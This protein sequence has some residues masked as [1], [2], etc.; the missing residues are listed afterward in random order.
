MTG[1]KRIRASPLVLLAVFA[2]AACAKQES[3]R[4][5]SAS[6]VL[7]APQGEFLAYEHD[8]EVALAG[9]RIPAALKA[10]QASCQRKAFGDCVVLHVSQQGGDHPRG[11]LTVRIV[12]AGV[13]PMIASASAGGEVGDRS[14]HA[15][16]LAEAVRDN[17]LARTRLQKEQ[18]RLLEFQQRRDL[19]VA[20]MIALSQQLSQVE[21]K[22]QLA[23]QEAAQHQRRIQTQKLTL[24]FQ[25][26]GGQSGRGEIRQAV[27]DF[28]ATL[29]TGT[30]W[31]I[32]AVAFLIPV[33][34]ALAI[35]FSL[36]RRLR[37]RKT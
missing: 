5:P 13:E 3:A 8:V 23:E 15:E 22:L 12:P 21:A 24:R 29:A 2:L 17:T 16:D 30:A 4:L 35:L 18:A 1:C 9:E 33:L 32:R 28:F 26:P 31:T 7:N 14:T 36:W 25:P 19:S 27:R 11:V 34:V 20:D 10:A 37:R 6:L